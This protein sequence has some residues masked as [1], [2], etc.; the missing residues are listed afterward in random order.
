[1]AQVTW[2]E[3]WGPPGR[4]RDRKLDRQSQHAP[5]LS[6]GRLGAIG[7]NLFLKTSGDV[8]THAHPSAWCTCAYLG[9]ANQAT[10][11]SAFEETCSVAWLVQ[12]K[13]P[14]LEL[15]SHVLK[16]ER[17]TWIFF[18]TCSV[19]RGSNLHFW[20]SSQATAA[21]LGKPLGMSQVWQGNPSFWD[22]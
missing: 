2:V 17:K 18:E 4:H 7:G 21:G 22:R 15:G 11:R 10:R 6:C 8:F 14:V 9:H 1:M 13:P 16:T 20:R 19:G 3:T 12:A 5:R